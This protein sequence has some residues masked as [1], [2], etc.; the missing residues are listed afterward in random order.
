MRR[1]LIV[2]PHFPPDTGASSHRMRLLAP[3][4]PEHG[5]VPTIVTV[6]PRD[7]GARTEPVLEQLVHGQIRVERVRAWGGRGGRFCGIGDLGLRA[8]KPIERRC[9]ELLRKEKYDALLITLPPH[10]TALLGPGLS[11]AS[12]V[13]YLL[14]YQDPWIGAWGATVGGGPGG[15][16]DWKS[17]FSRRLALTLEPRALRGVAGLVAVSE[18]T[19]AG[20]LQRHPDLCDVPQAEAPLGGE[21][22]DFAVARE[23]PRSNRFFESQDGHVHFVYVGTLLPLAKEVLRA[24]FGGVALL[25]QRDSQRFD[26]MRFHFFGTSN[27]TAG[28]VAPQVLPVAQEAGIEDVVEEHP[29]RIDYLDALTVQ[30]QAGAI[31]LIG[32]TERHYTASKIYPALL[33]GR[34]LLAIYHEESTACAPIRIHGPE[35]RT[36]LMTFADEKGPETVR[37]DI[38]GALTAIV[39]GHGPATSAMWSPDLGPWSTST[40]AGRVADC[41]SAAAG[42][43]RRG[44]DSRG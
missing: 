36:H 4:L 3:R 13:P 30:T 9:R 19:I 40:L 22:R 24:F 5:W 44:T 28:D 26:R 38:P 41:L 10:Y 8:L 43:T 16:P 32:S 1:V 2:S 25:R 14:D 39:D 21:P 20:L 23:N 15:T 29:L 34:P 6:D 17:R 37:E 31:L 42:G 35:G 11:R 7:I 33:A 27:Q 12:G 18:G